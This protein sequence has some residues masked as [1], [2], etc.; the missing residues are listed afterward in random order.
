MTTQTP[1]RANRSDPRNR[2]TRR[3][4]DAELVRELGSHVE[5][6][7]IGETGARRTIPARRALPRD[8][9]PVKAPLQL[10]HAPTTRAYTPETAGLGDLIRAATQATGNSGVRE[11]PDGRIAVDPSARQPPSAIGNVSLRAMLPSLLADDG[12]IYAAPAAAPAHESRTIKSAVMENSR[13]VR[14][15]AHLIELNEPNLE[16]VARGAP[17]FTDAPSRFHVVEP[18]PFPVVALDED[19]GANAA[20]WGAGSTAEGTAADSALPVSIATIDRENLTNRSFRTTIPRSVQRARNDGELE[21]EI[22]LAIALGLGRAVDAELLAALSTVTAWPGD[23]TASA[24]LGLRFEELR[25]IVGTDAA[26]NVVADRGA[27]FLDGIPADMSADTAASIVAAF[28]RFAIAIEPEVRVLMQRDNAGALTVTC[29]CS[30]QA[31][32]PKA[33]FAW[34]IEAA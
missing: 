33:G 12:R 6:T 4:S 5:I 3:A 19:A 8:I 30:T 27:L 15:G 21:A 24:A 17:V 18:A 9:A 23:F 1:L 11:Y 34:K 29:W 10:R 26:A 32:V 2:A 25:A 13:V 16:R 7:R 31:L 28:D 22:L 14:A 20:S